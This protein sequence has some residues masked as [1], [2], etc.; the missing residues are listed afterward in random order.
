MRAHVFLD[1]GGMVTGTHD[2]VAA[3][4]VA[5]EEQ[6]SVLGYALP[7]EDED[8]EVFVRDWRR[9]VARAS[10]M[11][12]IRDARLEVGRVVPVNPDTGS[13]YAWFWRSGYELGKPGVTRA[14][15]WYPAW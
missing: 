9:E 8:R 11:F 1:G 13:D 12:R 6:L 5:V 15:V 7:L 4:R 10:A 2:V 14:V 3:R